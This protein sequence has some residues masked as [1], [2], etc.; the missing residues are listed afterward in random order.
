MGETTAIAWTD[1]TFNIAW[2]C[3]KVSPG[4]KNCYAE[5]LSEKRGSAVWGPNTQRRIF[6]D[7]H[8]KD[9][10]KWNRK[11]Q[12]AGKIARVFSSSM[13][14]VFEDHPTIDEQRERL[15]ATIRA[16]P[17]LHWQLLTKR[18]D[19]IA[20]HLPADWGVS[21]Y[22]NVWLGVSIENDEYTFRADHLRVIAAAVRF[23]SY[24]PALGPVPSLDTHGIDW[25]IY[26]GESGPGYRPEDKQWARDVRARCAHSG[27]AFFHKQSSAYRTEMGIELD[28][29]IVREYPTPRGPYDSLLGGTPK[30][31]ADCPACL[32]RLPHSTQDHHAARARA[33]A[34]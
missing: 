13:C 22:P 12:A 3:I 26:G 14:D 34:R 9:P 15:W 2:G 21:G 10:L 17:W 29:A 8:W 28:G 24:E 7:V 25:I 11:A 23:I 1:H 19:R 18:S 20:S 6:G 16:T 31:D 32:R 30:Y 27:T 5:T 4:C 33:T